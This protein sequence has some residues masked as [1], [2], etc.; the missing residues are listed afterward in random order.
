[1][2]MAK[3][4]VCFTGSDGSGKSTIARSIFYSVSQ[5]NKKTRMIYGRYRP[6]LIKHLTALAKKLFLHSND[7]TFSDYDGF[8]NARRSLFQASSFASRMYLYAAIAEYIFQ[9][10]I[11]LTIPY[12]LGYSI[13]SDRYVYDTVINDVSLYAG[14]SVDETNN[15]LRKAWYFIPKPD[16]TFLLH[17]PEQVALQRKNDIP[18]LNYLRIRNKLYSEIAGSQRF[19][20]LDGTIDPSTLKNTVLEEVNRFLKD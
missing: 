9:I 1:M 17:V 12:R 14:L 2:I 20:F 4:F 3:I 19:L 10:T 15:I 18:S 13:I 6:L 7:V 16:I 8:L 5:K 11:K